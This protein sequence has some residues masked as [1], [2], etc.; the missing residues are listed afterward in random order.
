[1]RPHMTL[2]VNCGHNMLLK[3]YMADN[4]PCPLCS[5]F[6]AYMQRWGFFNLELDNKEVLAKATALAMVGAKE[7]GYRRPET[8]LKEMYGKDTGTLAL[9]LTVAGDRT[10]AWVRAILEGTKVVK[11]KSSWAEAASMLGKDLAAAFPDC[12]VVSKSSAYSGGCSVNARVTPHDL[13]KV[14]SAAEKAKA[15]ELS[16]KYE[17]GHFDGMHDIYVYKE[18]ADPSIPTVSY[19]FIT[20]DGKRHED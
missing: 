7:G 11:R 6:K 9:W 1:M 3:S 16:R 8:V 5:T 12:K 17:A 4:K 14:F 13:G 19:V 20:L 15:D 18:R 2:F 10:P